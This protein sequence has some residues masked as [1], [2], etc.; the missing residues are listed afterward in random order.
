MN[1]HPHGTFFALFK[2]STTKPFHWPRGVW[3]PRATH[4]QWLLLSSASSLFLSQDQDSSFLLIGSLRYREGSKDK[5][6][7]WGKGKVQS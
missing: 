3:K 6:R 2:S 4:L 7:F 5:K 1:A